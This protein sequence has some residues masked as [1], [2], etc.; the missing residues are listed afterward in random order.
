ME[1]SAGVNSCG[2]CEQEWEE[3]SWVI[4]VPFLETGKLEEEQPWWGNQ[5]VCYVHIKSKLPLRHLS[6]L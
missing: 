4:V 2:L 1:R 6:G 3:S 5:E